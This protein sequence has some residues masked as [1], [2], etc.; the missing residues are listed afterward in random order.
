MDVSFALGFIANAKHRCRRVEYG[1]YTPEDDL[2]V[3]PTDY[4]ILNESK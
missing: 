2:F 3:P 4:E 1:L